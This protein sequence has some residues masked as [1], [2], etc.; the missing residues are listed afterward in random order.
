M[1]KCKNTVPI[2]VNFV[3]KFTFVIESMRKLI[4]Y[5]RA[6]AMNA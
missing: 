3:A 4:L 5:A 1:K 2:F 6:L